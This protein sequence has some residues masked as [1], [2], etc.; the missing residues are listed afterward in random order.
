MKQ[1]SGKL[2]STV[3]L[4]SR[5]Q[6]NNNEPIVIGPSAPESQKKSDVSL[7]FENESRPCENYT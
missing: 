4:I 5:E 3:S 7:L 6:R 1:H 2:Y